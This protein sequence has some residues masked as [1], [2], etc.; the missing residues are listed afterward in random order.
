MH[1]WGRGYCLG[2]R[3]VLGVLV[4]EDLEAGGGECSVRRGTQLEAHRSH[5]ERKG[6][7]Q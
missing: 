3:G 2:V 4:P 7:R 1:V 6:H 5:G